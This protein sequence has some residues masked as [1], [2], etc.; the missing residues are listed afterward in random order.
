MPLL[1]VMLGYI[2]SLLP[3]VT[4]VTTRRFLFCKTNEFAVQERVGKHRSEPATNPDSSD[5]IT[6]LPAAQKG[7]RLFPV[8][9]VDTQVM[10]HIETICEAGSTDPFQLPLH[11]GHCEALV[12]NSW[13]NM[14]EHRSRTKQDQQHMAR[15][16]AICVMTL[17]R[18]DFQV[19]KRSI[20]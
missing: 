2:G 6:E 19:T 1:Y 3:Q 7:C 8:E 16:A 20:P 4:T 10:E 15:L 9:E 13:L 11:Y 12:T 14:A 17:A 5:D 18:L